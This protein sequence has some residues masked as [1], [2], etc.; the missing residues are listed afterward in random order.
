MQPRSGRRRSG[1][2]LRDDDGA[3]VRRRR[4]STRRARFFTRYVSGRGPVPAV[5]I[6]RQPYGILPTT[7]FSRICVA[8]PREAP[9]RVPRARPAF[10]R[11]LHAIL[12]EVD[13]DWATM[14][15][16]GAPRVG[17]AGDPHQPARRPRAAPGVGRV[18]PAL[19]REPGAPVQPA[20]PRRAR[21]ALVR[22]DPARA[23]RRRGALDA[24]RARSATTGD[25]RAGPARR[26]CFLGRPGT[27]CAGRWST[28]ARCRRPSRSA[29]TP[30]TAA[31]T[32]V[33]GRRRADVARRA[34]ARRRAS[35]TASAPTAL[36][37]LLLRHALHA[38]LV[39][40]RGCGC[41][42]DGRRARRRPRCARCGASRRSCT[43]QR[44]RRRRARAATSRCTQPTR[45][46]P[47]TP[48]L[49]V[50]DYIAAR[51][52]RAATA[53]ACCAEQIEAIE[54][55]ATRRPRGWSGARRAPRLCSY[56]LDA[57]RLG[58]RAPAA[59][60]HAQRGGE[61]D[62]SHGGVHLGAYGWLEDVRPRAARAHAGAAAPTELAERLRRPR[63]RAA[64]CATPPTAATS[65]RRRSTTPSTAAVLRTGYLANATPDDAGR[66]GGQPLLASGCGWRW[67]ARGHPQRP[68]ARR[69]ARL[70]VRARAARPPR[71]AP[72]STAFIYALR[73]AFP[74]RRRPARRRP[75][76]AGRARSRR[77]RRATS[78]T[79]CELVEH[80]AQHRAAH[81]PVRAA[82][83][84][85]RADADRRPRRSTPRSTRCSTSTT[86]SPTS[87]SPRAC[88]R[89]CSATPTASRRRST[90]TARAASR[91]SPRSC[92]TPR[93]GITLT[94]RVG[95]APRPGPTAAA[96]AGRDA[97]RAG[98]AGG[99]T[100]G[101]PRAAR[102][103]R[104]RLPRE[105]D[106]P[107]RRH[108]RATRVVTQADLGLQPID[109]LYARAH[110]SDAGA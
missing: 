27:R 70:P 108:R 54:L 100:P 77:S 47:A 2:F 80:V 72:R 38:R 23:A 101:S 31:T 58:P 44:R 105:L 79:A 29:P 34:A 75:T 24:A 6:G 74:L 33:A 1:Y 85:R 94:H 50:G 66:A 78:S 76:G 63:R 65:T 30:T 16:A 46:S 15:A 68:D 35:P 89:R 96:P 55:L 107:G 51:A 60:A 95:A 17:R 45:P 11:R 84:A 9:D 91:P 8:R 12:R 90:P 88:T 109:L 13:G 62:G 93:S 71:P 98:R 43:S 20:Q 5:R 32:C 103:R 40:T 3:G 36:L 110:A 83:P 7:A 52:R 92:A 82:G 99:R 19:R 4:R 53:T 106:R 48:A 56:R 69:A 10:L 59:R 49:L 102:A 14:A 81:L 41:T 28:T 97:A 87:R 57:W 86:P 42:L 61:G 37:Y 73:K 67:R 25:G 64:A 26:S 104:R 22:R 39:R 21:R 18:P